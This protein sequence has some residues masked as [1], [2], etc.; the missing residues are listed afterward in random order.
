MLPS[1]GAGP[2]T[3]LLTVSAPG[4]PVSLSLSQ[5]LILSGN[6]KQY[7]SAAGGM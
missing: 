7:L 1:L 3:A 4:A 2:W 5:I 6:R